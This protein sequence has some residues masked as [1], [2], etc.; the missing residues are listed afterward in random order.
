MVKNPPAM[1]ETW[2]KF[3]GWEN[4]LEKLMATHPSILDWRIPWIDEIGRL[5]S[6]ES[7]RVEHYRATS[8]QK[9]KSF[10]TFR[11]IRFPDF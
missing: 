1:W 5:Q 9:P 10:K 4:P 8:S 3:L 2:V 11:K 7:Q 6:M